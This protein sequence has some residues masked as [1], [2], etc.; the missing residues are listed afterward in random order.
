[1]PVH[2]ARYRPNH[3]SFGRF[4]LSNQAY[5]PVRK[6]ANDIRDR[7]RE[8][9]TKRTGDMAKSYRVVK[10]ELPGPVKHNP[11]AYADVINDD[12]AAIP[13]EFG[14]GPGKGKMGPRREGNR[15]LRKAAD[16]AGPVVPKGSW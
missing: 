1:M 14:R 6:A 4:I 11:R 7:A 10:G 5:D 15:T 13:D 9:A 8:T 2:F 3:K 16:A 12:P